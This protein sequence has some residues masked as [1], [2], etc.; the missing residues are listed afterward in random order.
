MVR[1]ELFPQLLQAFITEWT[2]SNVSIFKS[3]N[4]AKQKQ[5]YSFKKGQFFLKS[6]AIGPNAPPQLRH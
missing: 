2:R 3:Q 4:E 5:K 6:D 1:Y